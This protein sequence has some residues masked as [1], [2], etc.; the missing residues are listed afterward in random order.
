MRHLNLLFLLLSG[1]AA[2]VFGQ[3]VELGEPPVAPPAGGVKVVEKP[4]ERAVGE[5]WY[6][7]ADREVVRMNYRNQ[8]QAVR[9]EPLG[10]AGNVA[11]GVWGDTSAGYKSAVAARL[12]W[13]RAM[14][15]VPASVTL[16]LVN[17]GKAQQ[18]AMMMSANRQLS[19]TPP[20][21]WPHS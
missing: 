18:A 19:H 2:A 9:S 12:N 5:A 8:F 7:T 10:W 21:S 6:N 14:A 11:T 15:G 20:S 13:L 3:G 16:N 1:A 17:S 4:A